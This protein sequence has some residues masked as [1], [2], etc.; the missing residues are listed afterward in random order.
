MRNHPSSRYNPEIDF[1]KFV[2]AIVIFLYHSQKFEVTSGVSFFRRGYLAVE[3]FFIVSGY[4]MTPR[5]GGGI[6]QDKKNISPLSDCIYDCICWEA[7]SN[8]CKQNANSVQ[9]CYGIARGVDSANVWV[10]KTQNI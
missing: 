6:R 5:G 8:S 1:W 9:F 10:A 7:T 2:F 3:F 4:L